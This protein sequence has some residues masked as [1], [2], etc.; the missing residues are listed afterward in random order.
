MTPTLNFALL[1]AGRIGKVHAVAIAG[2]PQAQLIA[3]YDP[4]FEAS[5]AIANQYGCT[6]R[7]PEAIATSQDVDAVAICTPTHT[8]ADFI[9]MY[10]KAGKIIFCE[11]PID[12]SFDRVRACLNTVKQ[13]NAQLMVGFNRRFDPHFKAVREEIESGNIGKI[14]QIIITSRDPA[15]PPYEYIDVSGGIFRDMMIH[16][17]DMARFLFK[18]EIETVYAT[19]SVLID[20]EIGKRGDYDTATAILRTASGK[21]A[22]ITNSRRSTYGYDQRIEVHGSR[23]LVTGHN[24]RPIMSEVAGADGYMRRPLHNF[25][26]TRYAEAYAAEISALVAAATSNVPLSPTG[27]DG[28]IALAL[29]DAA[30]K[31]AHSQHPVKL[32]SSLYMF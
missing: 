22:V 31:S 24:P 23:G 27:T 1:G 13:E 21:Q 10:A 16:D 8:H 20:D 18:E 29:A 4:N 9:E 25:F 28:L 15:P 2:N 6:A 7:N 11:K 14:E 17:F 30:L 3:V 26:M 12:L 19:G 5:E 32:D